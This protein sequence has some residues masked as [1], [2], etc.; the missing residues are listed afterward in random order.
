MWKKKVERTTRHG[1]RVEEEEEEEGMRRL[2]RKRDTRTLVTSL[3]RS[4]VATGLSRTT[5]SPWD[6]KARRVPCRVA[7]QK[8]C[9][10]RSVWKERDGGR[11][12]ERER[13]RGGD[14][15]ADTIGEPRAA[16]DK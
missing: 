8:G 13:K 5:G 12:R 9:E 11:M 6:A 16:R 15:R 1:S 10:D 3:S 14:I 4:L 7:R 2:R